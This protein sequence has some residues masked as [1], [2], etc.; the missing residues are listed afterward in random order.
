[1]KTSNKELAIS[2]YFNANPKIWKTLIKCSVSIIVNQLFKGNKLFTEIE[3]QKESKKERIT[4]AIY[5]RE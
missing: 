5:E 3:A 4:W 2:Y 1:M